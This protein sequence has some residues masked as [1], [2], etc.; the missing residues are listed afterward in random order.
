M[1][2]Y[3][4]E[5]LHMARFFKN[6]SSRIS[7]HFTIS[8]LLIWMTIENIISNRQ[9]ERHKW[10]RQPANSFGSFWVFRLLLLL[11]L[12]LSYPISMNSAVWFTFFVRINQINRKKTTTIR[13]RIL[14][15]RAYVACCS[16]QSECIAQKNETGESREEKSAPRWVKN[17]Q[18]REIWT[19]RQLAHNDCILFASIWCELC[20]FWNFAVD[21]ITNFDLG[22]RKTT[23]LHALRRVMCV[24]V[25]E[26]NTHTHT[27]SSE[28]EKR[29]GCGCVFFCFVLGI[30]AFHFLKR[31]IPRIYCCQRSVHFCLYRSSLHTTIYCSRVWENNFN[32][33][34]RRTE[35]KRNTSRDAE[36]YYYYGW[37]VI[38]DSIKESNQKKML[39]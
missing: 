31:D 21:T 8:I 16:I 28:I 9:D 26:R 22:K 13:H 35:R 17:I 7:H 1:G 25:S 32:E 15:W 4:R 10:R 14:C 12:L 27:T 38:S 37:L 24:C 6:V 36:P 3:T 30:L 18:T 23:T 34:T 33:L 29:D 19:Q 5:H 2:K 11:L 39:L 20:V